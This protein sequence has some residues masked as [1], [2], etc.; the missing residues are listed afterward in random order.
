MLLLNILALNNSSNSGKLTFGDSK[1]VK[2]ADGRG[3]SFHQNWFHVN[4]KIQYWKIS[5]LSNQHSGKTSTI[6]EINQLDFTKF[7]V[8]KV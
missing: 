8:K 4:L 1:I 7:F 6:T 2:M 3:P 5:N